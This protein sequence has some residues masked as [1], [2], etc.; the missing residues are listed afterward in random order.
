M[1]DETEYLDYISNKFD[2]M[3]EGQQYMNEQITDFSK[4][5]L[6]K[7]NFSFCHISISKS[8]GLIAICKKKGFLDMQRGGVLNKYIIVMFQ[9]AKERYYISINWDYNK[10]YIVCLDFNQKEV[11][12]GILNDG[13]ILKIN[14]YE[15]KYK[16]IMTSQ[17]LKDEGILKAKFFEKGFIAMTPFG[18]FYYIKDIKNPVAI[19]LCQ[20]SDLIRFPEDAEFIAIS[21]DNSLSNK[22]ELLITNQKNRDGVIQIIQNEEGK[23]VKFDILDEYYYNIIGGGLILREKPQK[24]Y[25]PQSNPLEN[26]EEEDEKED[27]KDKVEIKDK[28]KKEKKDKKEK[29][30]K[31]GKK[32]K[33][34]KEEKDEKEEIPP[35]PKQENVGEQN[36]IGKI[37]ALAISPSGEK[38]AFYNRNSKI[39]FLMNAD[40]RGKYKEIKFNYDKSQYSE[41]ENKEIDDLLNYKVGCQF[42][43]CG[44]DTLALSRQRFILLSKPNIKNALAYMIYEGEESQIKHG[45]LFSKCIPETDGLRYLTNK[46]VFLISKVPKE[47]ADVSNPFSNSPPKK[48]IKIYKNTLLRKYNSDKDIRSLSQALADSI[49]NLQIASANIFWTENNNEDYKKEVQLFL[50]KAA[51]YAKKFVNKDDFNY[52]K[53]NEIC[54]DMRIINNLRNDKKYPVFITFRE[55]KEMN[56]KEII[57]RLLKYKNYKLA[58][59]ICKFLDYGIKKV[60]HKYVIA[61]MKKEI[62]KIENTFRKPINQKGK[63]SENEK[64]EDKYAILFYHLEKVPGI[65]YIKLAKKASKLGGEKLA[66]YLLEQEKSALIKIPQ[67]LQ[68]NESKY[69]E[70]IQ[71]AFQTYDFNAVIKVLHKIIKENNLKILLSPNLQKYYPKILLYLKK[72][73]KKYVNEFLK[74]TKNKTEYFYIQLKEF[75]D[76]GGY[77][78]KKEAIKELRAEVKKIDNDSFDTKF[79][80]KYLEKL[81]NGVDFKKVCL[82]EEKAIIHYS[83]IAPY[84]VSLYDCY[85]TG[86]MK[87]EA[88]RFIE[89]Q[90]KHFEYSTKK[91][92]I[93]K[94]RSYLELKRPDSVENQLE[95]TSL[96]K[97]GLTPMD[98]GEIYYDYK[99]YDKATEYLIKTKDPFYFSYI[100]DLLKIMEKYKEALEFIISNKEETQKAV[101]VD[102]ILKK[103]PRLQSYVDELCAK[104]KVSL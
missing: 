3:G 55:Y 64:T 22:M 8:G 96:K 50:I 88:T 21:S 46:G 28:E 11:L 85:K 51:Q 83:E 82:S 49:V 95:K 26:E 98:L 99:Y 5:D 69:E 30:H 33:N 90:N 92:Y 84:S 81:E 48:L 14:Y 39:A 47:L 93:L 76:K 17:I 9:N 2:D 10:R 42:L 103:Q 31:K 66:M 15:R 68:I 40:F 75:F 45:T 73:N 57:N 43:F 77:K 74:L 71:I 4:I 24:L 13:G 104:Y 97:M 100:V 37:C 34:K 41:L 72:Y 62:N 59:D 102:E 1:I 56:T 35:P 52:D 78:E 44:E 29:K 94:L 7:I 23:N 32:D 101:F 67:L 63:E 86:F 89:P 12:Y 58:A 80:K 61:I 18:N 60:L 25:I 53:F 38:I 19:T 16:E 91:L 79:I 54:K 27:K 70:A 20:F 6:F 65:S 36:E 87:G